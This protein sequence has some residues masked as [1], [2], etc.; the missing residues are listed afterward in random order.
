MNPA[1]SVNHPAQLHSL[2]QNA[3]ILNH[4]GPAPQRYPVTPAALS[5]WLELA[6]RSDYDPRSAAAQ[7]RITLRQFERRC[8]HDLHLR[9]REFL[10]TTRLNF[11]ADLL[12]KGE[13]AKCVA[14]Q[15]GYTH[16]SNFSR[17]FKR[18]TG[19]CPKDYIARL[20]SFPAPAT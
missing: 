12:A 3:P 15:L 11:A 17:D 13:P 7:L 18:H 1:R 20:N 4:P 16:L 10:H 5:F 8:Q 14:L 2:L 6:K 9:P 19:F